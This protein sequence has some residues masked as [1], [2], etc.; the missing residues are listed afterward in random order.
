MTIQKETKD[1][2][3]IAVWVI[4]AIMSFWIQSYMSDIKTSLNKIQ[5]FM[6]LQIAK[7]ATIETRVDNNTK[8]IQRNADAIK[9]TNTKIDKYHSK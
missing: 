9:N 8:D 7:N 5:T 4:I 3:K 2:I 1:W 6:E